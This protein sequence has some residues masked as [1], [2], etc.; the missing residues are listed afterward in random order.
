MIRRR[1]P[2]FFGLGPGFGIRFRLAP[3]LGRLRKLGQLRLEA[4]KVGVSKFFRWRQTR[5]GILILQKVE[6]GI[7]AR[8][9]RS[10]AAV[11]E[12]VVAL[13]QR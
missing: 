10:G 3:C 9:G 5:I 1:E 11:G 7:V 2:A 12:L 6:I 8:V 13:L 4:F